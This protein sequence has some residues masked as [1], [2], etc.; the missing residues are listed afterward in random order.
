MD[1]HGLIKEHD[2][3]F[4]YVYTELITVLYALSSVSMVV[5]QIGAD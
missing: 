2:I 1:C 4:L 5:M 3:L